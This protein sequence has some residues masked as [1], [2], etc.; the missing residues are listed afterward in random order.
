MLEIISGDAAIE[1]FS[2]PIDVE[3]LS[4]V[5]FFQDVAEA[6]HDD[7]MANDQHAPVAIMKIDR[8]QRGAEAAE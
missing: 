3:D 7:L 6:Q 4:L 8:V 2:L 1:D 5:E